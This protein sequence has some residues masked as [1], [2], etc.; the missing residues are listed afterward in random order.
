MYTEMLIRKPEVECKEYRNMWE[1][2]NPLVLNCV[3]I[4]NNT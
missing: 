4:Y 1:D 2:I 3:Y